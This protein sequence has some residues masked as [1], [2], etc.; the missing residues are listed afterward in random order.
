MKY[1][2]YDWRTKHWFGTFDENQIH[3]IYNVDETLVHTNIMMYD[4]SMINEDVIAFAH[5]TV[6]DWNEVR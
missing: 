4:Q 3:Q 1:D 5:G 6:V 2:L